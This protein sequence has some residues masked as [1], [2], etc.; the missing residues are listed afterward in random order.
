MAAETRVSLIERVRD[1]SDQ[2]AWSEFFAIYNPL[3]TAYVRKQ[4]ASEH[5]AADI[6]QDVFARLVTVL[7][8]FE[9]DAERGRFRTWLWYVTQNALTDWARRRA[10]RD[11]AEQG[12]IEKLETATE[13][14]SSDEWNQLYRQCLLD[15][16]I[17]RVQSST[18]P[19]TWACF[20]AKVLNDRPADE[21]AD[22]L[23]I[24]A[25]SVHVNASRVLAKVRDELKA[26]EEPLALP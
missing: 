2:T 26:C 5:D 6:V 9:L 1:H 11:R 22:E 24:S 8:S 10:T 15:V 23:G 18:Q 4:G 17:K 12:W 13:R 14:G 19:T 16:A 20:E 25:N 7:S 3:L 21:I